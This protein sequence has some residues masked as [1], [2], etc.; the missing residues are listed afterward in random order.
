MV[1]LPNSSDTCMM[2]VTYGAHLDYRAAN[3]MT[4][5]HK[6]VLSGRDENIAVSCFF[7]FSWLAL[8]YVV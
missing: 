4:V 8:F 5:M 6:A 3:G 2:L 7:P 1:Q